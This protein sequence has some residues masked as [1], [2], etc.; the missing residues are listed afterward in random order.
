MPLDRVDSAAIPH[1]IRRED[2]A[3]PPYLIETVDLSFAIGE[4][5]VEVHSDLHIRPNP[6]VPAGSPLNLDGQ[7]LETRWLQL[8][9]KPL[10]ADDYRIEG[11]RLIIHSVPNQPFTLSSLV[12][13][14][15]AANTALEGLYQSGGML[16]TQCE[17]EGFRRITWYMDRPDVMARFNVSIAA[18]KGRFPVLLSNGN[19]IESSDLDG[20]RHRVVWHDPFPKPCYLFALVAGDLALVD[21][22]FIT[23]SGR[24]VALKFWVEHGSQ[25]QVPHALESLRKAMAWDEQVFGLEYDLDVFN[26]VA[27]S[28]FNM[29]AMENKSLNIFNS[30]Y[31]LAKRETA[32]DGDF[33]GIESVI[34]HEYFHNWTGDRV[35]CR[36]WFQLTLKEGLTVFRDQE[37]SADMNSRGLQRIEDVRALRAAQFPE[38]NGPMAHP[39]RPESYVEINNFYTS[40]VYEKGAEVIRMIHTLIGAPAFR[41]GMDTYFA[42]HDGQA[43][44][45]EDFVASME[46]GSG[47]DL[48]QFRRWYSQAG[49]P[50]ISAR[51]THDTA[52]KRLT[53][54]LSQ[55]TRPTPGQPEKLPFHIPVSMG[56][57][58]EN[59]PLA[60]RL[61]GENAPF[62]NSRV[63]NLTEAEQSFVFEDVPAPALPSLF[64]GFSAPIILDAPYSEADL[65]FLM[66]NDTDAFN[67]WD[68]GQELAVRVMLELVRRHQAGEA[69]HLDEGFA[70]AWGKVLSDHAADVGFAAEALT[71]PGFAVLGERMD[72]IDVDAI[73]AAHKFLVKALAARF[74]DQLH[75]IRDGLAEEGYSLSPQSIGKRRMRN[76]ILGLVAHLGDDQAR[77]LAEAQFR[78]ATCMTDQLSALAALVAIGPQAAAPALDAFFRQ[79]RGE[80]LVVN[81]WLALQAG[82]DWPDAL[83]RVKELLVHPAFD[84]SEPNK[85]Y[86]L[87]GGFSANQKWFHAADGAG[88]AFMA[89]RVMALDAANPQVASRMVRS[90]MRWKRYDA[91]RQGLMRA[92]LERIGAKPGLS[93]DVGEIVAKALV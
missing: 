90:L 26:V 77:S 62:G 45:C 15:P 66:A 28:H 5:L 86:A 36:D 52:A 81:K 73:H 57:L 48:G 69:M 21:G 34:A 92:Q 85:I 24:E 58:G 75:S 4:R 56:L 79:W 67:R 63:L 78:D 83:D 10:E 40:T 59:G 51:W 93:R 91:S 1:A 55:S 89:D 44:T 50:R 8:N 19:Q 72:V 68:A 17:A 18:D 37:F 6:A 53:L 23:R 87:I 42:R 30:K 46:A 76:L 41:R 11:E 61:E 39:I 20:G 54:T 9:G 74:R 82:A 71:L 33:L 43:V 70:S 84:G 13:L 49:T 25:D 60:L 22:T 7:D 2:Y 31:V 64:R 80:K 47:M 29:G 3:P 27:V 38:D 14:D 88:Y 65:A 35:T 32:T 16:C 12:V